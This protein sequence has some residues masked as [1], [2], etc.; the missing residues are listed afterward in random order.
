MVWGGVGVVGGCVGE[1]RLLCVWGGDEQAETGQALLVA[2]P[3]S[4]QHTGSLAQHSTYTRH[5]PCL[6]CSCSSACPAP[7][8]GAAKQSAA[9]E[10]NRAW[11]VRRVVVPS[12]GAS[13]K[14]ALAAWHLEALQQRVSWAVRALAALAAASLHEDSLGTLLQDQPGLG[15]VLLVLLDLQ[16]VLQQYMKTVVGGCSMCWTCCCWA[17]IVLRRLF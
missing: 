7:P 2:R 17:V 1:G 6:R 4:M 8:A 13:D 12:Q 11:N 16:L 10:G 3:C 14:H 9:Q 5:A 15:D